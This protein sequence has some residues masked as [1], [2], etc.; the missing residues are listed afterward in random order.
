MTIL[1]ICNVLQ[2]LVVNLAVMAL[3][4]VAAM[5][6]AA[7]HQSS[8]KYVALTV[9][10]RAID[11][12]V[13]TA[14]ADLTTPLH[15]NDEREPAATAV[16]AGRDAVGSFVANWVQVTVV[17]E[18]CVPN[19]PTV[20]IDADPRFVAV[21][22]RMQCAAA[23]TALALNFDEF[24][25]IDAQH[26]AMVRLVAPGTEAV[27]L[28]V[29]ADAP[30]VE[31]SIGGPRSSSYGT[32]IRIGL[33]HIYS[34][35]DHLCFLFVLL[36]VVVLRRTKVE[37]GWQWQAET[38]RR[39]LRNTAMVVTAFT[40]AHSITLIAASLQLIALPGRVVEAVIAG[41]IVYT[42]VENIIHPAVRWRFGLT[43]GF[44]LIHG[45]GFA[46]VLAELLPPSDVVVP[47]L[48]FNVGVELGQ[49][50]LVIVALPLL[51]LLVRA[52]GT[53]HYRRIVMP[54]ISLGAGLLGLWWLLQR[55]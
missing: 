37:T 44:G 14:R 15:S 51:W 30:R 2:R 49:L 4:V 45:L 31:L 5:R 38:P 48:L 21:R 42:A 12:L 9:E 40:V 6:P 10:D 11:V 26:I 52:V 23:V 25:A 43:F 53:L 19:G 1:K 32:W 33:D 7:A 22:W 36:L 46:S 20:A 24:F 34:G 54:A 47:L 29:R 39:A 3:L 8:V 27:N 13:R 35:T 17:G 41:S 16:L 18:A 55:W 50:S 28:V